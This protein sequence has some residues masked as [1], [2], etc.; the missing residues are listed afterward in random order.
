MGMETSTKKD[1]SKFDS[2]QDALAVDLNK[3]L[4]A[5]PPQDMGDDGEDQP[6]YI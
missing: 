1:A 4:P 5:L 2:P 3:N 6:E